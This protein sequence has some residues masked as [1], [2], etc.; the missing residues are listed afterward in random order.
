VARRAVVLA[1]RVAAAAALAGC[2]LTTTTSG[3]APDG[4]SVGDGGQ[5]GGYDARSEGGPVAEGGGTEAGDDGGGADGTLGGGDGAT[6]DGAASLDGAAADGGDDGAPPTIDPVALETMAQHMGVFRNGGTIPAAGDRGD[7]TV[8]VNADGTKTLSMAG[9]TTG[10]R[11]HIEWA[12]VGSYT[13]TADVNTDGT[14]DERITATTDAS[15][16]TTTV[17][18]RDS[19]LNGTFDWRSTTTHTPQV[20]I[21]QTLEQVPPGGAGYV[22]TDTYSAPFAEAVRTCPSL[23]VKAGGA[24]DAHLL[25]QPGQDFP[26]VPNYCVYGPPPPPPP[27]PADAGGGGCWFEGDPAT[28]S[29]VAPESLYTT[30]ACPSCGY[31]TFSTITAGPMQCNDQQTKDIAAALVRAWSDT[32][33][34]IIS[35]INP[36]FAEVLFNVANYHHYYY[37]CS[38]P[39]CAG[40]TTAA[41]TE[42]PKFS[43]A[44]D[45]PV[46]DF[47]ATNTLTMG[48]DA[49]EEVIIHEWFHA[50]GHPGHEG[51][52]NGRG[53]RD[54][55]YSCARYADGCRA[56]N[57][58]F[59]LGLCCDAS[60]ARDAAM[61]ADADHKSAFGIQNIFVETSPGFAQTPN[62]LDTGAPP[63][64]T[65]LTPNSPMN[66][67]CMLERTAAYCDQTPLSDQDIVTLASAPVPIDAVLHY[68]SCCESCP[69]A[70]PYAGYQVCEVHDSTTTCPPMA[71]SLCMT[72]PPLPTRIWRQP[73]A[74][75]EIGMAQD[76]MAGYPC[77]PVPGCA[78]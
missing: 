37:G 59:Y 70:T 6:A 45:V 68:P 15:G 12:S 7:I 31:V 61:C 39:A 30:S 16:V 1:A 29:D 10:E 42:Q 56:W 46:T 33:A 20:G 50:G 77:A 66:P 74:A 76:P 71:S 24:C 11:L 63:L 64:C 36:T 23:D 38:S 72:T 49:I 55:V 22:T 34:A 28:T 26:P 9:K 17:W 43:D 54:M 41:F 62:G 78:Y 67:C 40:D 48:Q 32:E 51:T 53:G 44:P 5:G 58:G 27:P 4:S 2:T 25:A 75:M 57:S 35:R 52:R 47:H 65:D 8:T 13:L 19:N 3:T 60:S 14:I 21:T 73:A 69:P 18:E